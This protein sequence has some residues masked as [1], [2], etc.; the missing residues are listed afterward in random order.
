M[1][2]ETSPAAQPQRPSGYIVGPG[3]DWAF[4]LLPPVAALVL[5]VAIS[6][7][8]AA[9]EPFVWSAQDVTLTGL[10]VGVLI[11]AHLV[12]VLLRSHGNSVVLRRHPYRFSLVPGLLLMGMLVSPVFA[13]TCSVLATFWDVYHSGAQTF[14]FGRI[15]DAK[16]GNDPQE[17]RGLDFVLNQLLYAGPIVAGATMLDH[18]EDFEEFESVGVMLL[19]R[20]PALMTGHQALIARVVLG[21]GAAF[22]LYYAWASWRMARRGRA[23]SWQKV[24]LL[25]STGLV[26]IY[27]WGWNTWGE[28][29]LIMNVFH[30]VQYFGIVWASE[31]RSLQRRLRLDRVRGGRALTWWIFVGLALAYGVAVEAWADG[32][33]L[34]WWS[35]TIVVSLMHFWYDGFIWSVRRARDAA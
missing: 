4:F 24:Y 3:Y 35:V 11:Q 5:G 23:V 2:V 33:S 17:G 26:S 9:D 22:V 18:F 20:V 10:L 34:A 8:R 19:S 31:G 29:F 16:R 27:T 32:R 21:L 25:T 6:G 15:Y 28:A 13:I 1:V 7:T 30:A 12:I 14:G